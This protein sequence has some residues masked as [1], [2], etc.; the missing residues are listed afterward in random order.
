MIFAYDGTE[1]ADSPIA[2]VVTQ[3]AVSRDAVV[4][5]VWQPAVL[6]SR[7]SRKSTSTPTL[8]AK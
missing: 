8:P 5:C 3:L 2:Q 4:F 1:L 6:A 7:P